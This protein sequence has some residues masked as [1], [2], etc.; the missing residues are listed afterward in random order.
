[1]QNH[2]SPQLYLRVISGSS[3]KKDISRKQQNSNLYCTHGHWV[4]KNSTI[5][6]FLYFSWYFFASHAL[7]SFL[8]AAVT[9]GVA[10][11]AAFYLPHLRAWELLMGSLLAMAIWQGWWKSSRLPLWITQLLAIIGFAAIFWPA[12]CYS[13]ETPSPG[14]AALPPCLGAA[15]LIAIGDHSRSLSTRFLS[16]APMVFVGKLSYSL[17]LWHWP[18]ISL[19]YYQFG[20]L[21]PQMGIICVLL[22]FALSYVSWRYVEKPMRNRKR[23]GSRM[24]VA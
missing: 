7:G 1:M 17:Y 2:S 5:S 12:I 6:S 9:V 3:G 24:I 15:T 23:V 10:L 14:L 4:S 20:A 22:S 13:S 18:L 21:T 19:A 16:L 8:A 11:E